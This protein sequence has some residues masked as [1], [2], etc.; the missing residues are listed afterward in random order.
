VVAGVFGVL[1]WFSFAQVPGET[2][3]LGQ[4]LS[5]WTWAMLGTLMSLVS[6]VSVV[7]AWAVA[8]R[9]DG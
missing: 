1:A 6:L 9:D 3:T 4:T 2:K 7:F 5:L 8:D